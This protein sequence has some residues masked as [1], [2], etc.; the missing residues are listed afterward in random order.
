MA[1]MGD[2]SHF[3]HKHRFAVW[4]SAR[5]AQRGFTTVANL[6]DALEQSGVV[7]FLGKPAALGTSQRTFDALHAR[8]CRRIVRYLRRKEVQGVTFGRA[9]KLIA[10]YLKT[11]VVVGADHESSLARVAHPP[12]DRLL[13]RNLARA[14]AIKCPHKRGWSELNWTELTEAKYKRLI[15][16]LRSCLQADEP[17]WHLEKYWV[18]TNEAAEQRP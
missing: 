11:M 8:W 6:R 17:M 10:V 18:V 14:K 7:E 1:K 4:A 2:Y 3:T 13:L 16:Q 12:I 9:A 15:G 5:A